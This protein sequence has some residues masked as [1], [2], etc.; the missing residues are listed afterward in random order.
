MI[1]DNCYRKKKNTFELKYSQSSAYNIANVQIFAFHVQLSVHNQ[2]KNLIAFTWLF[3]DKDNLVQ[4]YLSFYLI[5]IN[6]LIT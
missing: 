3:N 4:K 5:Y 2:R 6:P 1:N